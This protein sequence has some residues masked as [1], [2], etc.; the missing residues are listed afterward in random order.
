LFHLLVLSV[1][2]DLR[3]WCYMNG[4]GALVGWWCS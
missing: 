2:K 3:R 4:C 1:A